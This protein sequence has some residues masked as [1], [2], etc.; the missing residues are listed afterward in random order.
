MKTIYIEISIKKKN[1]V[2]ITMHYLDSSS[3]WYP[4]PYPHMYLGRKEELLSAIILETTQGKIHNT[5]Y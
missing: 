3:D 4:P 5:F 1:K 2:L